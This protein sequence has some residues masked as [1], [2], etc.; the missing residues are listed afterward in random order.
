MAEVSNTV[1]LRD[2]RFSYLHVFTP[3]AI[4]DGNA[5][6]YSL[7]AL[8]PKEGKW[9]AKNKAALDEV[10]NRLKAKV[11]AAPENKGKLPKKFDICLRDGDVDKEDEVYAGH[12]YISAKSNTKPDVLS[13]EKDEH[14]KFKYITSADGIKSGDHGHVTINLF[15]YAKAGNT[16]IGAGLNNL[17]KTRDGVSLAGKRSAQDDF[18]GIEID[19]EDEDTTS[20]KKEDEEDFE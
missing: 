17:M 5:E 19:E 16:G 18:A 9:A 6:K 10:I 1:L 7:V 4:A 2:V 8:I 13:T 14:D 3:T 11:M 12:Y 20:T 15:D